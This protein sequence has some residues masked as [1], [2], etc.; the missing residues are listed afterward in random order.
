MFGTIATSLQ[1]RVLQRGWPPGRDE[2]VMQP[3]CRFQAI[4]RVCVV[5]NPTLKLGLEWCELLTP[6]DAGPQIRM[7]GLCGCV[8]PCARGS[9]LGQACTCVTK[10]RASARLLTWSH[11]YICDQVKSLG[12]KLLNKRLV[13]GNWFFVVRFTRVF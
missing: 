1:P 6:R 7:S 11:M 9:K 13:P 2:L 8:T 4:I 3:A 12:R 5:A 10:F